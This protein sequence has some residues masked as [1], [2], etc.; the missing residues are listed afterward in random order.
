MDSFGTGPLKELQRRIYRN[1]VSH[2]FSVASDRVG[3]NQEICHLVEELGELA[4]AHRKGDMGGVIDGVIDLIIFGLGLLEILGA[5]GDIEMEKV[6]IQNEK[7]KY[8]INPDGYC[9]KIE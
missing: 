4:S 6:I 5:D 1:K 8:K 3:I 7:R 9:E 2:D